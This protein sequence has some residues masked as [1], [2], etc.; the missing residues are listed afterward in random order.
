MA[1][2]S[3]ETRFPLAA[4]RSILR[5]GEWW[6][7]KLAGVLATGYLTAVFAD[8]PLTSVLGTL[9]LALGTLVPG[10]VYVSVIND[11]TDLADDARAGKHNR[12]AGRS[13]AAVLLVLVACLTAGWSL[14]VLTGG[15]SVRA[16][17]IYGGAWIAFTAYSVPPVRLKA[18]GAAGALAD[19]AGASLF[20]HL[21]VAVLVL[22]ATPAGNDG[23]WVVLVGAW[24]LAAGIRGAVWHQL[25]DVAAD[26]RAGV[27][28]F[29]IAHP[30]MAR[31][32]GLGAFVVEAA[33]LVTLLV[34]AGAWLALA[35]LVLYGA[36]ERLRF[37]CWGVA[38]L[39]VAPPPAD[40]PAGRGY[41]IVLHD[42]AIALLP[43]AVLAQAAFRDASDASV[44]AVHLIL[45]PVTIAICLR[46]A[47]RAGELVI[48][49]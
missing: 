25:G 6:E 29:A 20:P 13:P 38:V 31:R 40:L 17:L 18:R 30:A 19:A 11:L 32:V 2:A 35:A 44:L 3:P 7:H 39:V 14:L 12:L 48:R 21:L 4:P 22:D 5:A 49:R 24:A 46:D 8:A 15:G 33:A 41:R 43:V 28:T 34:V 9:L 1:V 16:L 27:T 45:F 37:R 10:A 47:W 23:R 42:Y 26:A 36:L